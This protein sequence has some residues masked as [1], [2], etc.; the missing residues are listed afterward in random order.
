MQNTEKFVR[1]RQDSG[2]SAAEE[3]RVLVGAVLNQIQQVRGLLYYRLF[4][5]MVV[6]NH[7]DIECCFLKPRENE[8]TSGILADD[9]YQ[10][11]IK[12]HSDKMQKSR[13]KI[14]KYLEYALESVKSTCT[15]LILSGLMDRLFK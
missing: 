9:Y 2:L 5:V 12:D 13:A 14:I 1:Q 7:C 3:K 11:L 6:V 15:K 8:R 10:N 4:K